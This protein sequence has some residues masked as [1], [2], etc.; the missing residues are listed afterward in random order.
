MAQAMLPALPVLMDLGYPEAEVRQHS[1]QW[2]QDTLA[3]HTERAL[4]KKA[5]HLGHIYIGT[6]AAFGSKDHHEALQELLASYGAT[7]ETDEH[8]MNPDAQTDWEAFRQI[9]GVQKVKKETTD[10]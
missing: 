5:E 3:A 4:S 6:A 1:P 7:S 2:V 8:L 10:G 9:E